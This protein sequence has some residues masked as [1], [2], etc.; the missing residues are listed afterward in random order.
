M[1]SQILIGHCIAK[2]YG[3]LQCTKKILEDY[4]ISWTS[5]KQWGQMVYQARC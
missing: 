5:D 4:W 1:I 2:N 3:K